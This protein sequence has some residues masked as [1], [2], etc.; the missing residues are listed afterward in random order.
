MPITTDLGVARV[1]MRDH[2]SPE[3]KARSSSIS[4]SYTA[5]AGGRPWL[6]IRTRMTAEAIVGGV[7]G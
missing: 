3:S 1:W 5:P 7:L 6:K 2:V 4:P